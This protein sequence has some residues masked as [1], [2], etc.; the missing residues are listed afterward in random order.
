MI[1]ADVYVD[2]LD[3]DAWHMWRHRD[4]FV[5]LCPLPSTDVFQYQASMAPGQD[6]QLDLVNLQTILEQRTGRA[7]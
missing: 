4:G 6:P 7:D 1:V 5:S 3:R 2:G